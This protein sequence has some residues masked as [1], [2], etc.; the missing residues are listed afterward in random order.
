MTACNECSQSAASPSHRMT[1]NRKCFEPDF[2]RDLHI[3]APELVVRRP[4][5]RIPALDVHQPSR[6]LKRRNSG[7]FLRSWISHSS[8][9]RLKTTPLHQAAIK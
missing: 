6:R 7:E 9:Q 4:H 2:V 1:G 8:L 3:A 5:E